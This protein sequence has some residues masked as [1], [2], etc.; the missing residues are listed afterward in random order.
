VSGL[1]KIGGIVALS[2]IV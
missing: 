2:R 1:T